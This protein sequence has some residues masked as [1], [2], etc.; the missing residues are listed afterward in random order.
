M[1]DGSLEPY[2]AGRKHVQSRGCGEGDC[3]EGSRKEISG[4]R[5]GVG[6]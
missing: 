6:R 1:G 4:S 3:P 5:V 2:G